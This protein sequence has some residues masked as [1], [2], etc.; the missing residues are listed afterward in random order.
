ME[1]ENKNFNSFAVDAVSDAINIRNE[2][3]D[4]ID[5]VLRKYGFMADG[6][7]DVRVGRDGKMASL[8]IR[9]HDATDRIM[10][11]PENGI[12]RLEIRITD[13]KLDTSKL[14]RFSN[15]I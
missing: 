8:E 6:V 4:A 12:I 3:R 10:S 14:T 11:R 5:A 15:S 13:P 7:M 9:T 1:Q 2:V